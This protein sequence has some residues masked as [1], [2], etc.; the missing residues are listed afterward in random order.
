MTAGIS[1]LPVGIINETHEPNTFYGVERN[2]V[3]KNIIPTT[4][5]AAG[6]GLSQNISS[7][8]A[9]DLFVGEGLSVPTSGSKAFLIRKGRQKSAEANANKGA[10]TVRARWT[11]NNNLQINASVQY[12][13][14]ITQG[15]LGIDAT[16][17]E[18][19]LQYHI[20]GFT[21]RALYARWDLNNKVNAL[22][23]GREQQIGYFIEPSYRFGQSNQYGV[24]ARFSNWDN[25]AG[26]DNSSDG[27][28]QFDLG[29]NYWLTPQVVFKIDYQDQTGAANDDGFHL[30]MGYA[31]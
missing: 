4:W 30:G 9:Y 31:F 5:W 7:Q 15:A 25:N 3:E 20:N 22:S 11:P 21:L 6:L 24:F 28:D 19:N 2:N 14:D 12:Q 23:A 26:D 27:I 1:L 16:L 29:F 13:Q 8:F 10:V 17:F 18:T